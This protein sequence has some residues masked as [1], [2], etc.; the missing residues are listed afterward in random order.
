[1]PARAGWVFA[2]EREGTMPLYRCAG[3]TDEFASNDATCEG[4]GSVVERL[5]FALR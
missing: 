2:E 3:D 1:M 5:G 4:Q